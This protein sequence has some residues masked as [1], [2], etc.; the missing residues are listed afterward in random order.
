MALKIAEAG[1]YVLSIGK[2]AFYTQ[3][4]QTN[5]K[6]MHYAKNMMTFNNLAQ[7]AQIGIKAFIDK[8]VPQ[9][10]NY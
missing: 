10:E 3:I 4:D 9:W 2:Q 6:A 7:D 5:E 8:E 1:R